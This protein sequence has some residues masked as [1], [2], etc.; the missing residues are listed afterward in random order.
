MSTSCSRSQ[1]PRFLLTLALAFS[2]AAGSWPWT[3]HAA[4]T[5]APDTAAVPAHPPAEARARIEERA[6]EAYGKLGVSFEENRGQIDKRVRFLARH[7]GATV[8]LTNEEAS[9]VLSAPEPRDRAADE[10]SAP[11]ALDRRGRVPERRRRPK[12][13]AVRMKFEGANPKA[14][15]SGEREL[16][17]LVNYLCYAQQLKWRT[18]VK[19]YGAV[20]YRGLYEGIDLV[21]Y[22][23]EQGEMEYDFEVSPGADPNRISLKIEGAK[24]VKVDA[25][26]DL[27]IKTPVGPMRQR[28]PT[29]YQEVEGARREVEGGYVVRPGGRV[30]FKLGEYDR[31]APLVIDPE[32]EYST[33]L[34]G[35]YDDFGFGIAVDSAGSAYV[36]GRTG[37]TDFPLADAFQSTCSG[38]SEVFVTKL[39]AAGSEL[40]Y[41]T[42]LGGNGDD[43]GKGIAVDSAGNAYVTGYTTSTNFP[44][45][46]ALQDT[47]HGGAAVFVTKL[48][49]DGSELVYS[50]YLNGVNDDYGYAVAV[51][52]SGN[53]YVAGVTH[54]VD[55]PTTPNAFQITHYNYVLPDAFV[56]KL[57]ADGSAL[58]YSTYLGSTHEDYAYGVAVDSAGHAYVTGDTHYGDFPRKNAFQGKHGGG[59]DAF[60]TKLS[61]DGSALVY[62]TFLGGGHGDS[63]R[64]IAADADG[65]AYVTGHTSSPDFPVANA[66][67]GTCG[68]NY[69]RPFV[70]KL[71]PDGSPLYSTCLGSG[72][73]SHA[74]AADADGN[75]YV[76]AGFLM[77]KLNADGSELVYSMP[78]SGAG[79]AVDSSG[80]VYLTGWGGGGGDTTRNAFQPRGR[81]GYE[82]F[83][84]KITVFPFIQGR[85]TAQG[86]AGPVGVPWATV[87]L[88][89]AQTMTKTT[90]ARGFYSFTGL[91]QGGDYAVTVS[92]TNL[93][94]T[95][96]RRTFAAL[97]SYLY[98]ADFAVPTLS[99]GDL[100]VTER[101]AGE[102]T[103]NFVV[104]LASPSGKPVTV[105]YRTAG[106]ATN[107]ASAGADYT[108]LPATTLSFAP[109]ETAKAVYVKIKGDTLDETNET[110][111]LLLSAPTNAL[112]S[113]NTGVCTITDN[114][115]A[116]TLSVNDVSVTEGD[117]D[118]T[119][120]FTVTLSA[121][122]AQTVKVMY[123]TTNGTATA[124]ADFKGVGLTTLTF[125][126]GETTKTIAVT[127]RGDA[128]AEPVESFF[129]NLNGPANA[130]IADAQGQCK[131]TDDD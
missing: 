103:A 2:L 131:I 124:P 47:N 128:A 62:S 55:F 87:K 40:V 19:T 58:V 20:R 28:K 117:A 83:V 88:T 60:V 51:D 29:V 18:N 46:N 54:S 104:R 35:S 125:A 39:N 66:S 94:F 48:S 100:S 4:G 101:N 6:R 13:H 73:F 121:A 1:S 107:S 116:P 95:P 49:A 96:A 15:V 67:Q 61:P 118:V 106:G 126:P 31:S 112:I 129:V 74:V 59:I 114:D 109:W 105:S 89:G 79:I 90:D 44:V 9:F 130:T 69:L 43:E 102:A 53:A 77:A 85:V 57:N 93:S 111:R 32:V 86:A 115:A 11:V 84:M 8:Y 110:F 5:R 75:A 81:G 25:A 36:T 97:D 30:R 34:G 120:T 92:K 16:A 91:T 17:G 113:D 21:Y 68:N 10:S 27:V 38:S 33:Y 72:T 80:D 127:V 23:N 37:S 71:N 22:G 76:I 7:G 82:A 56:T 14:E 24:S 41:S 98:D 65:N 70:T 119:A 45:A 52:S 64:G 108:A 50:T 63:G 122:S 123:Q 99:V 78:L 42:Y 12:S 26:G 3:Q